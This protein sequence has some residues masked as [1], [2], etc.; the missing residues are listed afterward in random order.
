ML[1][2]RHKVRKGTRNCPDKLTMASVSIALRHPAFVRWS[3]YIEE[4][5]DILSSDPAALPSDQWLCDLVRLQHISEDASI[6]FSMDDPGSTITLRD[7]K[8]QYQIG[9]FRQQ[10]ERWRRNASSDITQG[11]SPKK[12]CR[13]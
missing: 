12:Y 13:G 11:E 6:V 9:G 10:L 2:F 3:I 5:L 1:L 8:V 7:V 4:C